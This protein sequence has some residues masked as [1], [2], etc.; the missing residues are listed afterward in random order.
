MKFLLFLIRNEKNLH[1]LKYSKTMKSDFMAA[2]LGIALSVFVAY[3]ALFS[4]G[5]HSVDL[6]DFVVISWYLS[7]V[8]F[9]IIYL[10]YNLITCYS[11]ITKKRS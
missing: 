11:E 5:T 9:V 4:I 10:S 7:I 3:F 2:F 1:K 8:L 6:F